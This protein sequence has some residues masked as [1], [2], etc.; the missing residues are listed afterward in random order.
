MEERRRD[1]YA[2]RFAAVLDHVRTHPDGDLRLESLA[3]LA[4]FSPYHF[5]RVFTAVVGE[6]VAVFVR[7]A[8]L[9]RA[10]QLMRAAPGRALGSIA[11]DAGFSSASDFGRAFR[12][13]YGR[14][15][16]RWNRRDPLVFRAGDDEPDVDHGPH[17]DLIARDAG[18]APHVDLVDLE[19]RRLAFVRVRRPFEPGALQ[20][21]Y[22]RLRQWLAR[23]EVGEAPGRLWGMSW[24]DVD[25]TPPDRIRYDLA[26]PVPDDVEAAE[27]VGVRESPA[28]RV[29]AA[30]A[31]GDLARVARVWHHLY[32]RWLPTSRYEPAHHPAF[33]RYHA[34][35]DTMD[36]ERWDLECCVPV[37]SLR[38]G[39]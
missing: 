8:R 22:A 10:V 28:L 34:W 20:N 37:V 36:A 39:V 11:L 16:S 21:G 27:G 19:A 12:R 9:E 13:H 38:R 6:T 26:C 3:R 7:R 30:P 32:H 17:R 25:V 2:L 15:P 1:A 23:R 18:D 14:A 31:R 5:H 4:H 24:D 35:P 33:E 29:A